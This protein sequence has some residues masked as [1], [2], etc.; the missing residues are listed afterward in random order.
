MF[1]PLDGTEPH[2]FHD[3]DLLG[4]TPI[5]PLRLA[6]QPGH[7][8]GIERLDHMDP[9]NGKHVV[10]HV[11]DHRGVLAAVYGRRPLECD[12][13]KAMYA[14]RA[15]RLDAS[16]DADAALLRADEAKEWKR[17]VRKDQDVSVLLLGGRVEVV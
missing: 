14:E 7:Y 4:D 2:P 5:G 9:V 12:A 6:V 15:A 13:V 10:I 17:L 11:L 8:I 16:R 1:N 3:E